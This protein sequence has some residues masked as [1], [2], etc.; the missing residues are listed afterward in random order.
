MITVQPI[1]Y[2]AHQAE[3]HQLAQTL[4]F[5]AAFPPDPQWSEFD[6]RGILAVHHAAAGDDHAGRCDLHL[7]SDDLDGVEAR[8]TDA[9]FTVT[10]TML[11]D[12][13][14]MLTITAS[15]GATITISGGA[16]V[17][18]AGDLAVQPIWYQADLTEPRR[19]LETIGLRP[20]IASDSGSWIDFTADGGGMAALHQA[21]DVRFELGL[22]YARDLDALCERLAGAGFTASIIDEAYN[23]TLLVTTPEGDQ[24]WINGVQSDLYGFTRLDA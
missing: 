20:R 3:W 11:D 17:A 13:G 4:G 23:R 21:T 8:L 9:G 7:L 1:R 2:T 18:N 12:I 22:E 15:S 24:L 16:R 6:G 5:Q 14:P 10:R 19:I